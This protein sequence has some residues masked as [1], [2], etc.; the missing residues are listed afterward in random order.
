MN[1][2]YLS[3]SYL[4]E[5]RYPLHQYLIQLYKG[6]LDMLEQKKTLVKK[7]SSALQYLPFVAFFAT[8]SEMFLTKFQPM[9]PLIHIFYEETDELLWRTM[10]KF[11]KSK[12][13]SNQTKDGTTRKTTAFE[14]LELDVYNKKKMKLMKMIDIGTKAKSLFL[15]CPFELDGKEVF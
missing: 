10:S 12:H 8:D 9:K 6:Q 1:F 15:P 3:F 14:L 7:K 4:N 2:K 5:I 11:V 13:L